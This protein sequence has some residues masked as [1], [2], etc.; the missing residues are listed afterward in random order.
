MEATTPDPRRWLALVLLCASFFMVILDTAI[1]VVAM[2]SIQTD[3]RLV[4]QDLQWILSAYALAYGGL[5]LFGGRSGDLLGRRRVFMIGLGLFTAASLMSGL[6]WSADSL[7]IARGAQGVGAALM[8]PS[9]LALVTT[10][11][12]EGAERN[13]ALGAW[14]AMGAIG[15][16]A[17]WLIG[18]PLTSGPGWQW[19]FYINLPVGVVGLLLSPVLLRESRARGV[20]RSFDLP[21]ALTGTLSLASLVYAI[22]RAPDAGWTSA[23]TLTLIAASVALM[24][25][26]VLIESRVRNPLLPLRLL[27][28]RTLSGANGSLVLFSII[29]NGL[30]YVLTLYAQQILGYSALKFGLTAIVFPLGAVVGSA[31]GQ[32]LAL[33]LGFRPVSIAGFV[34][35]GATGL[36]MSRVSVDGT[37]FGDIFW[38]LLVLGPAVGLTF[39]TNSVAALAGVDE[40]DAGIASGLSNTTFQIGGALGVA[41]MTTVAITRT[42]HVLAGTPTTA[43]LAA[44]TDGY[45]AAFL[46]CALVALVGIVTALATMGSSSKPGIVRETEPAGVAR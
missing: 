34:L 33:K 24:V 40:S 32:K 45:Q 20:A 37:Y 42:N 25:V 6:S 15:G 13:K 10:T 5:L 8:T 23:Q 29:A 16:A 36:I 27:R 44:L 22:V 4:P 18:G 46:A 21:G 14:V 28:S 7:I 30:P 3:L 26:F 39:V 31:V 38:G 1:V 11:F 12:E 41:I 43:R 17:G 35:L 9:A 2:P 19:I